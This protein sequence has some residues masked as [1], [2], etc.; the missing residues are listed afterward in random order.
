MKVAFPCGHEEV[1]LILPEGSDILEPRAMPVIEDPEGSVTAAL[2]HPGSA[3]Q[4]V[5]HIR[6]GGF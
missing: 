2:N 4:P 1:S 3:S 6:Q 5:K